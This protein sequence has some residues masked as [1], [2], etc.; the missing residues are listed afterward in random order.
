MIAVLNNKGEHSAEVE[1]IDE[2]L[3]RVVALLLARDEPLPDTA[4]PSNF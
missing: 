3:R 1:K 4:L 2:G